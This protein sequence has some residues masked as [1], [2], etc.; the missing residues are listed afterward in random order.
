IV[1]DTVP[2]TVTCP[3]NQT[4]EFTSAAGAEVF[5]APEATDL[6]SPLLTLS[7]TPP[8][9]SVFPIGT[10][11][12]TC[13]AADAAGNLAA[14]RFQVTVLGAQ[15]VK[16]NILTELIGFENNL[17]AGRASE[18]LDAAINHLRISL[19]PAFW[20][21]QTHLVRRHGETVFHEEK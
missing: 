20:L 11:E 19:T 6:C 14:C 10:T 18:D 9:G 4:V 15:G 13:S 7:S 5:F 8:S 2:P 16:S 12:V 3:S 17:D 21:D 1:L